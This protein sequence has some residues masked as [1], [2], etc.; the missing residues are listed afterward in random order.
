MRLSFTNTKK[1]KKRKRNPLNLYLQHKNNKKV[2]N[3]INN[4]INKI[5]NYMFFFIFI[6]YCMQSIFLLFLL[7]LC[8][9]ISNYDFMKII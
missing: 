3:N 5:F 6:S 7:C 1:K 9:V 8:L 2:L 4:N